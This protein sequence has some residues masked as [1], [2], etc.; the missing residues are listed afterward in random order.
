MKIC[1][2]I[3]H[4]DESKDRELFFDKA[5]LIFAKKYDILNSPTIQF[6]SLNEIK[7]FIKDNKNFKIKKDPMR[8]NL[9]YGNISSVAG[10]YLA[11]K[12][13]L[14]SNYDYLIICEDDIEIDEDVFFDCLNKC[15]LEIPKNTIIL[16]MFYSDENLKMFYKNDKSKYEYI[17]KLFQHDWALCNVITR[18]G[19]ELFIRRIEEFGVSDGID[20][21]IYPTAR[22]EYKEFQDFE[23]FAINP[24]I[25]K[26]CYPAMG[27]ETTIHNT[28]YLEENDFLMLKNLIF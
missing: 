18:Y 6:K 12:N 23:S 24:K 11:W 14:N 13:F 1:Y 15:L 17:T 10:H 9:S 28:K 27:L 5:N 2:K 4:L 3:L 26:P 20:Y 25:K 21:I 16:S 22:K 7:N 8:P 19:A